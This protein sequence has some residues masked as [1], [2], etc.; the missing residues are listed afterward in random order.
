MPSK[1]DEFD[2]D[3]APTAINP[4]EILSIA[5]DASQDQIKT[6]Y[7]KSALKHHPDKASEDLKEQAHAKF[8]EVAF[9]YAILSDEKRKRR[10]DTTGNTSESLDLEDDDFDWSTFFREQFENVVTEE[11]INSFSKGYKGSAE[12]REHVLRAYEHRKGD[13]ATMYQEIMLSDMLEDEWRFREMIDAAIQEGEVE[14]YAKYADESEEKVRKRMDRERKRREKEAAAA[15]KAAQELEEDPDSKPNR[16][17]A[18]RKSKGDGDVS[19]LAALIQQRQKG[20]A[21]GFFDHLEAKYAA[22]AGGAKGKKGSKRTTPM[23]D[24]GPSEEAFARNRKLGKGESEVG[25][26]GGAAGGRRSSK[27]SKKA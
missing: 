4:Y 14:E 3:D 23:A 25:T 17:K 8:Q 9:A 20:R 5:K 26:E 12:E 2:I 24:D 6:A 13:M 27:R 11:T 7:R 15:E 22:P 1:A 21:E 19:D 18:K 10:Y 16:D